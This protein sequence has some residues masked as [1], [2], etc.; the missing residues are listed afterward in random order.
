MNIDEEK[1]YILENTD[2]KTTQ[3]FTTVKQTD[4]ITSVPD[5]LH[6]S[7]MSRFMP[8]VFNTNFSQT[9]VD[10]LK[11]IGPYDIKSEMTE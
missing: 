10:L 6:D 11:N 3:S 9:Y 1:K 5:H 2:K 4:E 7:K 8:A